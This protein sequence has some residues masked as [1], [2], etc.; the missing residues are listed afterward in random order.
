MIALF[1]LNLECAK[2]SPYPNY[3]NN[4]SSSREGR[5]GSNKNKNN[6]A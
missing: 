3:H 4:N 2:A 1:D 5:L 6:L